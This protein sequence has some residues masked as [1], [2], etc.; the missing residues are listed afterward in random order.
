MNGHRMGLYASLAVALGANAVL[1][2][3]AAWNR[4][5]VDARIELTERECSFRTWQNNE[6]TEVTLRFVW[7]DPDESMHVVS[8]WL[9]SRGLSSLGFDVTT[10][11]PTFLLP[12]EAFL[13]LAMDGPDWSRWIE[14]RKQALVRD[15]SG[16]SDEVREVYRTNL[17]NAQNNGSRLVAVTAG[18]DPR[19]L[20]V[21]FPDRGRYLIL[22]A[23]IIMSRSSYFSD[24]L[25]HGEATLRSDLI[26]VPL[27]FRRAL[28]ADHYRVTIAVGRSFEPWLE[29]AEA[30]SE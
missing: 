13:V 21:R 7:V 17:E 9:D 20:R 28:A 11:A 2:A 24:G 27:S 3:G 25:L 19:E 8:P 23:E 6:G 10:R 26:P 18:R 5:A 29:K 1:L 15:Y 14:A 16:K 12:R 30:R 22:P 4:A